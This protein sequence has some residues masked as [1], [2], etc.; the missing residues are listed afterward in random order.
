VKY[1][2]RTAKGRCF[3]VSVTSVVITRHVGL[4]NQNN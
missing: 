2:V 4:D 1:A 3:V